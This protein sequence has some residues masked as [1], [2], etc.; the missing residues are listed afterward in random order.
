MICP[1]VLFWSLWILGTISQAFGF[2]FAQVPES[3]SR[4]LAGVLL[5]ACG[6]LAGSAF[7][8]RAAWRRAAPAEA[9]AYMQSRMMT[10]VEGIVTV[11]AVVQSCICVYWVLDLVAY[12][13]RR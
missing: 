1:R 6:L 3:D 9:P 4:F 2:L 12:A 11:F 7:L 8:G 13:L 5:A 10:P